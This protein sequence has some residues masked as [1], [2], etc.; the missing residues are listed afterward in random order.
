MTPDPTP[1]VAQALY[2]ACYAVM[3]GILVLVAQ[4]SN[5]RDRT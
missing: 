5:K 4:R 2:L 1:P 3:W